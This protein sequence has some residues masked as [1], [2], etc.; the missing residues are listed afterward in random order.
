MIWP[1]WSTGHKRSLNLTRRHRRLWTT[2]NGSVRFT[3]GGKVALEARVGCDVGIYACVGACSTVKVEMCWWFFPFFHSWNMVKIFETFWGCD[4][5]FYRPCITFTRL[6]VGVTV[7]DSG[8]CCVPC[9][10]CNT[11]RAPLFVDQMVLF[12]SP[13]SGELRTQKLKSHLVRT[14]SLNVLPLKSGVGQYVAIHA[15]LTARN[16]FLAYFYPSSPFTC[17]FSK[18]SPNFFLCWLWLTLDPV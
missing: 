4:V 8:L 16:F 1:S 11:Y 6:L 15:T 17:I 13:R 14:Q 12:L 5:A 2:N 18:T 9:H 3:S 10:T 7:G